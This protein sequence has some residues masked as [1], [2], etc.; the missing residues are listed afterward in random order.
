MASERLTNIHLY[1]NVPLDVSNQNQLVFSSATDQASYFAGKLFLTF[2]EC[3]YQRNNKHV[4]IGVNIESINDC[5]YLSFTNEQFS[6]RVYYAFVTSME[7][8]GDDITWVYFEID[9]WQTY[10]FEVTLR[11]CLVEREH[12]NSDEIGEHLIDEGLA[13][14]DYVTS[15]YVEVNMSDFYLV[16]GS[17]VNLRDPGFP[18]VGGSVIDNVF[19][20][21]SF[22][23]TENVYDSAIYGLFVDLATAG[24]TDAII[25]MYL[26]PKIIFEQQT[27]EEL[28]W[29]DI[30]D[31]KEN[32]ISCPDN[33]SFQGYSPVN[34][35][36]LTYP[37]RSL[38]V[39]NRDGGSTVLRYEF[40]DDNSPSMKL[41][42]AIN[43]NG[44]M[45][46]YPLNYKG[47][48]ENLDESISVGSYPQCSWTNDI[49]ANWLAPQTVRWDY[50]DN[51]RIFNTEVERYQ[52][53][54]NKGISALGGLAN[55]DFSGVANMVQ[56]VYNYE[57]DAQQTERDFYSVMAQEKEAHDITPNAVKGTVG[58]ANTNISIAKYGFFLQERTITKE[59]AVI[60]D[61]YL[62]AK[63]Y[64]VNEI[65][66][67]NI[68]G[69]QSWNYVKTV[70]ANVFGAVPPVAVTAIKVM[71]D[72][73]VTFWHGDYVG[74]YTRYN[75]VGSAPSPTAFRLTVANGTGTGTYSAGQEV[76]ITADEAD[77]AFS[78]WTANTGTFNDPNVSPT[79]FIMPS[80]NVTVTAHYESAVLQTIADLMQLDE[81]A[82]EWDNTVG[83]I[84]RWYYGSYVK[85]AWC[86]TSMSYY[87]N[88]LGIL[89]VFPK[90]EN[91][92]TSWNANFALHPE[93]CWRTANYGG[94]DT[95][96]S[97]GDAIYFSSPHT[98]ADLT[99]VGVVTGVDG[100][101]ISYCSGNTTNPSGGP[102]GIFTKSILI[103]NPYV[104]CFYAIPY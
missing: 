70:G 60:I 10:Q 51:R 100:S 72:T 92:D 65:K 87:A 90:N 5:N 43:P 94:T 98:T 103:T 12:V 44:R 35:K 21:L 99:H 78:H 18:D 11:P 4:A 89:G 93:L 26:V 59:R 20:G 22:F 33:Q 7:Y 67:P 62:S 34:N 47:C 54:I 38:S 101:T 102:D 50:T 86:T 84:Q 61:N 25:C 15:R 40:F 74:D 77:T 53:I 32:L 95:M 45:V 80:N 28:Q 73:G 23:V 104:V 71:F 57:I 76:T 41:E 88:Q 37:Y 81:G 68:T 27:I 96:P 42:G 66:V 69:R 49:Y 8:R 9:Y 13:T 97:R 52:N 19:S 79:T 82:V 1:R 39:T 75:G 24:K 16:I 17:T 14:G 64:R 63:G 31:K 56:S 2:T 46:L 85:A 3:S 91:V 48:P 83:N 29:L 58:N 55:K 36:L 30:M 6:P